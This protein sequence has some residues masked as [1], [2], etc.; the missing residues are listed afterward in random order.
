MVLRAMV[1]ALGLFL[2]TK[3]VASD[4]TRCLALTAFTEARDQ[5]EYAMAL[6]MHTINNRAEADGTTACQEAYKPSQYF[7]VLNWPKKKDPS[8]VSPLFWAEALRTATKVLAG[9][10]EFGACKG[11]THFY[12]PALVAHRPAWVRNLTFK[13]EYGG[14]RFYAAK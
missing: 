1:L 13:C 14:H 10:I 5:G 12:A 3:A 9:S 2:S 4:D 6:V 8:R 7:G 11:A